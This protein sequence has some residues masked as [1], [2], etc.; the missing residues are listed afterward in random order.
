[1]NLKESN[2]Q[3]VLDL[4]S[5]SKQYNWIIE[6]KV[7]SISI[8]YT[9]NTPIGKIRITRWNHNGEFDI[10]IIDTIFKLPKLKSYLKGVLDSNNRSRY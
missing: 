3:F 4:F 10:N 7:A 2:N 5:I 9:F 6:E 8:K 1:M